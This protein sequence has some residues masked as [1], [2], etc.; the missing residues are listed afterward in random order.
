MTNYFWLASKS[1]QLDIKF[2]RVSP[3]ALSRK[4]KFILLKYGLIVRHMVVGFE[5]GR[6]SVRFNG[7]DI[8]YDSKYGLADFQSILTRHQNLINIARIDS[9]KTVID[10]GANVG[11]FSKLMREL[12]SSAKIYAVEPIPQTF[13]CLRKN[14]IH[15]LNTK[16]FNIAIS[17]RTGTTNMS[18]DAEDSVVSRIDEDGGI[19]VQTIT[20]DQFILEN[21]ISTIDVLKID[22]ETFEAHVLRGSAHALAIT[23]YLF[24]EITIQDNKNYT[25][26]SIMKL[27]SS[28]TYDY[29]LIGFRNY[30]DVSEGEVPILDCLMINT[31]F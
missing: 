11:F 24:I 31:K 2:L 1:L 12:Y 7:E 26:S 27:L 14:F 18:F 30:A 25:I 21:K 6:D 10:V 20:L 8:F 9:V 19:E 17:D 16:I 28:G 29:Q 23:K 4:G 5:L 15:D 13:E 3:L 22:T